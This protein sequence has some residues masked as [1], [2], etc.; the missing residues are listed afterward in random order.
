MQ[1]AAGEVQSRDGEGGISPDFLH[2]VSSALEAGDAEKLRELTLDLHAA[3]LADLIQL[4]RPDQR[5]P[6]ITTL[7]RDFDAARPPDVRAEGR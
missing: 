7:G 4:L 5:A 1:D 3:D 2:E 6:L